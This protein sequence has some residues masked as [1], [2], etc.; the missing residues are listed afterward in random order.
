MGGLLSDAFRIAR[1]ITRGGSTGRKTGPGMGA[2]SGPG[3]GLGMALP[4]GGDSIFPDLLGTVLDAALAGVEAFADSGCQGLPADYRLA[5]R[6]LGLSI[7]L[8]GVEGLLRLMHDNPGLFGGDRSLQVR[9]EAL[10]GYVPLGKAVTGFWLEEGYQASGPWQEHREI[11]MVM[12]AT[13][14]VP[15]GFLGI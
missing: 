6:E 8:S 10:S 13:S 3:S 2:D 11:N 4:G 5:F 15:D 7:G 12:L 14:L 1:L 9:A